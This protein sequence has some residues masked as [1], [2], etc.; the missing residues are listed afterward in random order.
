M[1]ILEIRSMIERR[2]RGEKFLIEC[3]ESYRINNEAEIYHLP[4]WLFFSD[5]RVVSAPKNCFNFSQY[6]GSKLARQYKMSFLTSLILDPLISDPFYLNQFILYPFCFG[7]P[8]FWT[9]LF[10]TTQNNSPP[11]NL[12]SNLS[13]ICCF[14]LFSFFCEE[15]SNIC[16]LI[17]DDRKKK[18]WKR[19]SNLSWH[20]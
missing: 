20:T 2:S 3:F 7:P 10:W 11:S 13:K 9:P 6:L 1:K 15:K 8:L 5:L 16:N 19:D 14:R 17:R 18:H 12:W 4:S